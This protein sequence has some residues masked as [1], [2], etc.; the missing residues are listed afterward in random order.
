M[1]IINCIANPV[2]GECVAFARRPGN[3]A[4]AFGLSR[5]RRAIA[6]AAP[7]GRHFYGHGVFAKDGR[8]LYT[9]EN[10]IE[11]GA[12]VIGVWDATAQM[13]H[14]IATNDRAHR[15]HSSHIRTWYH[16]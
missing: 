10:D 14:F 6:F 5:K 7:V 3:F 12:G 2:T 16:N 13:R 11:T 9:T 8:V 1:P 4:I 15:S